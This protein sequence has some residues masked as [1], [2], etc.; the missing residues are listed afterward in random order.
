MTQFTEAVSGLNQK[1]LYLEDLVKT[2][3]QRI[4]EVDALIKATYKRV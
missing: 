2:K 1:F 3:Y 4:V